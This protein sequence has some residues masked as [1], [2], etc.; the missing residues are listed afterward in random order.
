MTPP[1]FFGSTGEIAGESVVLV[2]SAART[3]NGDGATLVMGEHTTLRLTLDVTASVRDD[4]VADGQRPALIRQ[5]DMDDTLVLR[6]QDRDG[7][8]A[9]GFRRTRPLCAGVVDHRRGGA[10]VHLRRHRR[11]GVTRMRAVFGDAQ[12]PSDGPAMSEPSDTLDTHAANRIS[13]TR[14]SPPA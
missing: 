14:T 11:D 13:S 4:A 6:R 7:H 2:P 8:R 1:A 12:T 5:G 9:Q 3:A 10:V